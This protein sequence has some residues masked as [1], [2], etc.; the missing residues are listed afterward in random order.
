MDW[1]TKKNKSVEPKHSLLSQI[2]AYASQPLHTNA[3]V[4]RCMFLNWWG[5]IQRAESWINHSLHNSCVGKPTYL[6]RRVILRKTAYF[7]NEI[8]KEKNHYFSPVF[9]EIFSIYVLEAIFKIE[10]KSYSLEV[11][12]SGQKIEWPWLRNLLGRGRPR[13]ENF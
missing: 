2:V 4:V 3:Q 8:L 1:S 9:T 10:L 7:S 5:L 11:G 6:N 13:P 12:Y